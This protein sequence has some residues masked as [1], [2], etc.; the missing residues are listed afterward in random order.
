MIKL[1]ATLNDDVNRLVTQTETDLLLD[2]PDLTNLP[3]VL[4]QTPAFSK[5]KS[6]DPLCTLIYI[7]AP[8]YPAVHFRRTLHHV[9]V[10]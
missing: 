2:Q 10:V 8:I 5:A 9:L 1:K 6:A 7:D 4:S 3:R